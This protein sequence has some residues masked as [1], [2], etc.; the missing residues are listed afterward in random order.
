MKARPCGRK[1]P[2]S[3]VR[4]KR[5]TSCRQAAAGA[6][7]RGAVGGCTPQTNGQ[8]AGLGRPAAASC[9]KANSSSMKQDRKVVM[10]ERKA[11]LE[12]L[13]PVCPLVSP[14]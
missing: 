2:H 3:R 7:H 14:S 11:R 6:G 1:V 4:R 8:P 10:G 12:I 9:N 13:Q 5:P